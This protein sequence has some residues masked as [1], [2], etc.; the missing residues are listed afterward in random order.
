MKVKLFFQ[1]LIL[2]TSNNETHLANAAILLGIPRE[3]IS[4]I[5]ISKRVLE[6]IYLSDERLKFLGAKDSINTRQEYMNEKEYKA[7][8]ES[9]KA[10]IV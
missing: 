4:L 3:Y 9:P 8:I 1:I 6:P 5:L 2:Y 7:W 10:E